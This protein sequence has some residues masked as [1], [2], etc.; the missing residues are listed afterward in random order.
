MKRTIFGSICAQHDNL[1]DIAIRRVFFNKFAADGYPLILLSRGMPRAY[2]DLF[3]FPS[4]VRLVPNPIEF[5]LRLLAAILRRRASLVYAPGPHILSDKPSA[6]AKTLLLLINIALVRVSGG[7][8]QTAGRA[9][10]GGGRMSAFLERRIISMSSLYAVRD[11]V[12]ETVVGRS[13]LIAP[14][15]ALGLERPSEPSTS[16]RRVIA[17]SFRSDKKVNIATLVP[18]VQG[19]RDGGYD[20]VL[21]SQVKRDDPQHL[22]LAGQLEIESFLWGSKSHSEQQTIVDSVYGSAHAVISNRLHGLIFGIVSGACP[23]E[24]RIGG[25]DKIHSTLAPWFGSF[26][27][28]NDRFHADAAQSRDLVAAIVAGI[29]GLDKNVENARSLVSETLE[30]ASRM[31]A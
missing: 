24:Y 1:G 5:Q 14:D 6:L 19:L 28:I 9:L 16:P 26:P 29:D 23:V 4:N 31:A 18:L 2:I 10:R 15:L 13:I 7:V 20:V 3:C 25:S 11:S 30:T 27:I 8:I 22:S 21:V 12:S 17:F